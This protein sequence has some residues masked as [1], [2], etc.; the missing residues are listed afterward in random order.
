MGGEVAAKPNFRCGRK[1]EQEGEAT[2]GLI[3]QQQDSNKRGLT[4]HSWH[5]LVAP[6]A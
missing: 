3:R 4:L 1:S 5:L 6:T 2:V